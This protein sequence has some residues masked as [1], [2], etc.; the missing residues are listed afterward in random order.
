LGLLPLP[1]KWTIQVGEPLFVSAGT[2]I[3]ATITDTAEDV[4]GRIDNMISHILTHRR[5]VF[6]G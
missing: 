3:A 2:D 4:R 1:S 5:S 6:F